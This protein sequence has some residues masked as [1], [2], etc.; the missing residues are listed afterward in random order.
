[1]LKLDIMHPYEGYVPGSSPGK[2][3]KFN[4]RLAQSGQSTPLRMEGSEVRILDRVPHKSPSGTAHLDT[5][6]K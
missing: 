5:Y 6:H 2:P 1:M 3:A 4:A